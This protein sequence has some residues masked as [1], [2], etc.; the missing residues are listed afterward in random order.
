MTE[1]RIIF[2][3]HAETMMTER[4]IKEDWVKATIAEPEATESDPSQPN[5]SRAFRTIPEYGNRVLRVVY[6]SVGDTI[7]VVTVFFDRARRR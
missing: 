2:T 3:R 1:P 4:G 5:L 6:A 7:R